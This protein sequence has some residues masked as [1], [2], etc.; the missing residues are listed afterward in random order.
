MLA[1]Q[2]K[3]HALTENFQARTLFLTC[4]YALLLCN[5][6]ACAEAGNG[7]IVKWKDDKGVTHYGDRIPPQYVNRESALINRQGV[8]IKHNKPANSD[9]QAADIA[10]IEQDKKDKALL[11]AFTHA[12]EIDLARDRNLQFDMIA[13]ENLEQEK[14]NSQKKLNANKATAASLAKRKKNVPAELQADIANY[15]SE[16][17]KLDSLINERKELI[18]ATRKRFDEDKKR[19]IYLR[20]QPAEESTKIPT[21]ASA[22]A[23]RN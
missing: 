4:L 1:S 21:P 19:Y 6:N 15:E 17:E 2:L 7:R 14:V 22:A 16:I 11:G 3:K 5:H 12:S 20:N 9:D 13:L 8:T 23:K 18:E 10:K